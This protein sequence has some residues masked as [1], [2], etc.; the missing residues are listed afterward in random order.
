MKS[1]DNIGSKATI[2]KPESPDKTYK[3]VW[4]RSLK[5]LN[6]DKSKSVLK[7]TDSIR[8]SGTN[9]QLCAHLVQKSFL[10]AASINVNLNMEGWVESKKYKKLMKKIK[11]IKEHLATC[12]ELIA[13]IVI[14]II[15]L[16]YDEKFYKFFPSYIYKNW[17]LVNTE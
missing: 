4:L 14:Q 16:Y 2:N 5:K 6:R 9:N 1:L 11:T 3:S 13:Y 17:R 10:R 7:P 8:S 12:K 15:T